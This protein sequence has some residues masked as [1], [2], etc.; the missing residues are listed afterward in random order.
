MGGYSVSH[1]K[2]VLEVYG[3]PEDQ[4]PIFY[5]NLFIVLGEINGKKAK[6]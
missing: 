6:T 1:I 5:D 4:K 3:V 2:D